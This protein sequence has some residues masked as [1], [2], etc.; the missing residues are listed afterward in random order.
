MFE[1]SAHQLTHHFGMS[2]FALVHK[3]ALIDI[4]AEK[5]QVKVRPTNGLPS[6]TLAGLADLRN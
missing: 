5:G 4:L 3:M 1:F 6:Y 2:G